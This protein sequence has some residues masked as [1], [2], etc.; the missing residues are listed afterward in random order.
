MFRKGPFTASPSFPYGYV[1]SRELSTLASLICRACN[2]TGGDWARLS[3]RVPVWL[4]W[5]SGVQLLVVQSPA[6]HS[7]GKL[8]FQLS[9]L[10]SPLLTTSAGFCLTVLS[11]WHFLLF[12][13]SWT[14]RDRTALSLW[15]LCWQSHC[16]CARA[17][18]PCK[19]SAQLLF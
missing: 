11:G 10:H 17:H 12:L 13:C 4:Q 16:T 2:P 19:V 14:Q 7:H 3:V 18:G 9:T 6:C 5:I 15:F 1:P 8:K